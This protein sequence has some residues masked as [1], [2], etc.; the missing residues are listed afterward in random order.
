MP[1]R[2][3]GKRVSII[4]HGPRRAVIHRHPSHWTVHTYRDGEP[5]GTTTHRT[6]SAATDC[7]LR[8]VT[9]RYDH[10]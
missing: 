8:A 5:T 9:P 1:R 10:V 2:P 6:S 4:T 7:A 3:R